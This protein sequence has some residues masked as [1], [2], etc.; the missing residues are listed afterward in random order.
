MKLTYH[1]KIKKN[2]ESSFLE[3]LKAVNTSFEHKITNNGASNEDSYLDYIV[4][5]SKYELLYVRLAAPV[6]DT[7]NIDEWRIEQT[8]GKEQCIARRADA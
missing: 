6:I 1:L 2:D 5:L 8:D 3:A 4:Q 7:I